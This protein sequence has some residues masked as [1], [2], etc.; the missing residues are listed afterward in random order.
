MPHRRHP[1]DPLPTAERAELAAARRVCWSVW[2]YLSG[3]PGRLN[4]RVLTW[5]VDDLEDWRRVRRG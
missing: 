3:G 4:W 1:S 2:W 5:L